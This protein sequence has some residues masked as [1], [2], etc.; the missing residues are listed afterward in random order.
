MGKARVIIDDPAAGDWNMAVDQALL[1]TANSTGLI[2]VRFY[3]WSQPTFSLG[4]FQPLDIPPTSCQPG[5]PR[6]PALNRRWRDRAR[7]GNHLQLVRAK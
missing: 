5:L 7:P 6:C 4:Y 1:E 2:S 3:T